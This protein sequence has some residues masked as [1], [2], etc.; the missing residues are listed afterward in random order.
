MPR[1]SKIEQYE[2]EDY[3]LK[4]YAE[5]MSSSKISKELKEE[6]GISIS[7]TA[8]AN[9]LRA[10]REERAEIS[11]TIVQEHIQ[12]TIPDD[13]Q[14]LDEMNEELFSWFKDPNI[15]KSQ[16]L[17]IYDRLL[18][19]IDLKLKNSGAGATTAEDLLKAVAERWG[20]DK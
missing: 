7:K 4:K 11:K 2:L 16:K 12:K 3:V 6:K 18:R 14:K 8:I 15:K 20:L 9:F 10:V 13:L 1:P 17:L 19:G 5:G